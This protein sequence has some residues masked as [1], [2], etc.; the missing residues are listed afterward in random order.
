MLI[1]FIMIWNI[2]QTFGIFCDHLA[3]LHVRPV[4][5]KYNSSVEQGN[6]MS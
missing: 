1:Y 4:Y 5:T 3:T 6:Q 2:L